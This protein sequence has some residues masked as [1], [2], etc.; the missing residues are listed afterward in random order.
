MTRPFVLR[1]STPQGAATPMSKT[2]PT[3]PD[4][5]RVEAPA[6]TVFSPEP[7]LERRILAHNANMMLVEHRMA[8][9]WVGSRHAHPHDQLVYLVRGRI[10]F[11]C[12]GE[13]FE[14]GAG[15]SF[16]VKGGLE[17]SAW[18]LEESVVLD[19]FTPYREDYLP[20]S[21]PAPR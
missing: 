16:V 11:R 21:P 6:A 8:S 5:M 17:H 4:V 10:G 14:A 18:A 3:F 13:E 15:D 12:G 1:I 20:K 2:L 7:G 9:G 19:V